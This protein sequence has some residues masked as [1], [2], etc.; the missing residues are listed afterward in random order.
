[1]HVDNKKSP[2]FVVSCSS[3]KIVMLHEDEV[4]QNSTYHP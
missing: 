2:T 3:N 1:M 4:Y